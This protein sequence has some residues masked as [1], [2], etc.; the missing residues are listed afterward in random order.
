MSEFQIAADEEC[1]RV[2]DFF[3]SSGV[4]DQP[5]GKMRVLLFLLGL[6][7]DHEIAERRHDLPMLGEH[8]R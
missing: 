1:G 7:R 5:F 4:R 2:E 6:R 3:L 8:T